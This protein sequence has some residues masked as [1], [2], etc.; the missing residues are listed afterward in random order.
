MLPPVIF[1]LLLFVVCA[2]AALR[3]RTDERIAAGACAVATLVTHFILGPMKIKYS[4]VEPGL[5]A[6]D[7]AMLATFVVLA[8]RSSR[9]WPLWVAGLQLTMSTAHLLKA[10]EVDLMPRAYAAALVFWS[11]PIL[12]IILISSWRTHKYEDLER[13]LAPQ[14]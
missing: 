4:T 3:G 14:G 13:R 10:V 9:F 12:I 11:Y 2:S 6:L 1:W 8:L 7:L 5:M